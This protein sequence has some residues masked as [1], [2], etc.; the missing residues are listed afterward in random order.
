[1]V[2]IVRF[3]LWIRSWYVDEYRTAYCS[4]VIMNGRHRDYI[5]PLLVTRAVRGLVLYAYSAT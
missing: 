2:G 1:M 4:L 5:V 3:R